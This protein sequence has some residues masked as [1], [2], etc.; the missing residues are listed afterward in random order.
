MLFVDE[1]SNVDKEALRSFVLVELKKMQAEIDG[2]LGGENKKKWKKIQDEIVR[3]NKG[4]KWDE[5]KEVLADLEGMSGFVTEWIET[6]VESPERFEFFILSKAEE[7]AGGDQAHDYYWALQIRHD[8]LVALVQ[9]LEALIPKMK[10]LLEMKPREVASDPVFK[11][12]MKYSVEDQVY[13]EAKKIQEER[14][15]RLES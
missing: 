9:V 7:I 6:A 2:I 14:M 3:E 13:L 8:Q 10:E 11:G 1:K 5:I 4:G 15:K 12:L